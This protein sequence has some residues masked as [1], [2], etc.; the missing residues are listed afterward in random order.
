MLTE[1]QLKKLKPKDEAY[2]VACGD[3]LSLFI[4]PNGKKY[5]KYRFSDSNAKIIYWFSSSKLLVFTSINFTF[6]GSLFSKSDV[7]LL[8]PLKKNNNKQ[9]TKYFV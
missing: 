6:I 7:L 8:H 5:W 4:E 1:S 2:Q 9:S 3:G